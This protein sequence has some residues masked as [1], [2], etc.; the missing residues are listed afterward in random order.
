[1]TDPPYHGNNERRSELFR[2]DRQLTLPQ[3]P[4]VAV[5]MI[6]APVLTRPGLFLFARGAEQPECELHHTFSGLHIIAFSSATAA[7]IPRWLEVLCNPHWAELS[8][9]P[10]RETLFTR[11]GR[12]P[13]GDTR[14]W[15]RVL[16]WPRLGTCSG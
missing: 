7:G 8:T 10:G 11:L 9:R 5:R 15:D 14:A 4:Q 1:M 16:S 12:D 13:S 6:E 3:T 2:P